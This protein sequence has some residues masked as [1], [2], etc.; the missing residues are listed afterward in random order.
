[1]C[2]VQV[3]ANT[4]VERNTI[5]ILIFLLGEHLIEPDKIALCF[6]QHD[7]MQ[8]IDAPPLPSACV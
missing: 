6:I 7:C 1:M 8:Y 5:C 2:A 3:L 4:K